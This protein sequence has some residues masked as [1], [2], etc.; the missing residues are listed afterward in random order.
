MQPDRAVDMA[1]PAQVAF[2]E[3]RHARRRPRPN[4]FRYPVYFL[5]LPMRRLD[6]ALG[7]QRVLSHNRFNLLSFYDSDH[8]DPR[9]PVPLVTWI[10]DLLASE[11]IVDADGEIWLHAFPRVL[12]YAF[13]PV[14]FWFCHR[15]D[16]AL[17]AIVCEINNTF[18]ERHC[19]LLVASAMSRPIGCRRGTRPRRR[20]S[21]CRRSA[22]STAA[23]RFRFVNARPTDR[24]RASNMTKAATNVTTTAARDP[25]ITTS[26]SG[27]LQPISNRSLAFHVHPHAAVLVRRRRAHPLAGRSPVL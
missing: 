18:G 5:R 16:G 12:G 26:L 13:K 27:R 19:Y 24:R 11:G 10:T 2:G 20:S 15:R 21:T 9:R 14:S 6:A 4:A 1:A 22:R 7:D 17:R 8:G 25:L 3:V 23:Y